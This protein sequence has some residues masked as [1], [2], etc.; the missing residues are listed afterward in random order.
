MYLNRTL[1]LTSDLSF[2]AY[3]YET[4]VKSKKNLGQPIRGRKSH[5]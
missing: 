2:V 5:L 4:V 3:S 1:A